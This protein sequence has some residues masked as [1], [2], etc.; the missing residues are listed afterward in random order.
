MPSK[1]AMKLLGPKFALPVDV[2]ALVA[3]A[4]THEDPSAP[5]LARMAPDD[6]VLNLDAPKVL[7]RVPAPVP[8]IG[9][10][11][12]KRADDVRAASRAQLREPASIPR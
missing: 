8:P 9:K 4:A 3:R 12:S 1:N 2:A 7:V 11:L 5:T 10:A 6:H